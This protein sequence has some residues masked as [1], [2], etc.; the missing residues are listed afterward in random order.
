[1][2]R[3]KLHGLLDI[4]IDKY[5]NND[6]ATGRLINYLENILPNYLE[7]AIQSHDA[8]EKRRCELDAASESFTNTFL[9]KNKYYYCHNNE[10]FLVYDGL[11]FSGYSE[12]NIQHE[13]LTQITADERLRPWKHKINKHIIKKIKDRSPLFAIPESE[14][15]QFVLQLFLPYFSS[16]NHVKYFLTV[17]GDCYR[18]IDKD[19]I[20][21][22]SPVLKNVIREITVQIYNYFGISNSLNSIKLKYYDHSYKFTRLLL[23]DENREPFQIPSNLQK[24]AIDVLCVATHYSQ[25]YKSA[26]EFLNQCNEKS[27]VNHS[28]YLKQETPDTIIEKFINDSIHNCAN[29]SI[30]TKSMIFIWKKFMQDFK[31]PNVIFRDSLVSKIKEKLQYDEATDSFVGVTSQHLPIVASFISFWDESIIEDPNDTEFEIDEISKLF[32]KWVG[33]NHIGIDDCFIIELIRHFYTYVH[34]D[35]NKYISNI[36]C[37]TWDKRQDVIDSLDLFKSLRSQSNNRDSDT[38]LYEAYENY[39]CISCDKFIVSKEYFEK[40]AKEHVGILIDVHGVISSKWWM[41][42]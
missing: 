31:I 18:N 4:V 20:Y 10:L 39:S 27:L 37:L 1:M 29:T 2:Q 19:L 13:I 35:D 28:F 30:K 16:R 5:E 42:N 22:V 41:E 12:D 36:K 26:D 17:I 14:T 21:I 11:H 23:I 24:Y 40:V 9:I 33:K 34:V 7:N 15:I 6:Y 32:K 38:S 3:Q 25:R 8:R